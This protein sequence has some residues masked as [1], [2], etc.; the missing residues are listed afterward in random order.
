[1][2]N[3]RGLDSVERIGSRNTEPSCVRI[4]QPKTQLCYESSRSVI[5]PRAHLRIT[6]WAQYAADGLRG[7]TRPKARLPPLTE[8]RHTTHRT[9]SR[10][11]TGA[12]RG[13][14]A[15]AVV[16]KCDGPNE[17]T[18]QHGKPWTQSQCSLDRPKEVWG[19]KKRG[20]DGSTADKGATTS[21]RPVIARIYGTKAGAAPTHP[22][23]V[24][25]RNHRAASHSPSC[26]SDP[27]FHF[28]ES[29]SES[30]SE[31]LRI[32]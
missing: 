28:D 21:W 19:G 18:Q 5:K 23:P 25:V 26:E 32:D 2:P 9:L 3:R 27:L 11:R 14:G 15:V 13:H 12:P 8:R 29:K 6:G 4:T 31:I 30:E 24:T 7:L 10:L 20:L 17:P 22:S 1:M 16:L